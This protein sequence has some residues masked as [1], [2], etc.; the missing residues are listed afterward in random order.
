MELTSAYGIPYDPTE[1]LELLKTNKE[2]ALNLLWENLYHQ[3][4]IGTASYAAAPKLIE[5]GELSL[6]GAIEVAR[7][8][9]KN[10]SLPKHLEQQYLKA[11]ENAL[12]Q[13]P[14]SE[15]QFQGYYIIHAS[16]NGQHRLA[17]ALNLFSVS[18]VLNEYS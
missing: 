2:K 3:G 15:D 17:Q 7:H 12:T 8:S 18:E 11:L 4:D 10:P 9:N 5:F 13:T 1:A 6:V 14:R 16:L